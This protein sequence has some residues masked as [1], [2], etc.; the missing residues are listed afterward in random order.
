MNALPSSAGSITGTHGVCQGANAVAYSVGTIAN[1]TGYTWTLPSGATIAS[2]ANTNS[3][4][5]NFSMSAAS[6]NVTVLGTNSCGVGTVSPNYAV[7]VNAIPSKP[8]V[9][10]S[11]NTLTSSAS[12]GNQWYHNGTAVAGATA[13]VYTVPVANPGWYW[14]IVTLNG[15]SSDSSNHVY[16]A[17]VGVQENDNLSFNVYPVPNNG[18]FTAE[19]SSSYEENFRIQIYNTLGAM[20]YKTEEFRVS[21]THKEQID[22]HQLPAG[23]YSVVFMNDQR[24]VVRKVF[25]NK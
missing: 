12:S 19:V 13:Q 9:T 6:G 21:G 11:G 24:K 22:V 8:T 15:C 23:I 4:T 1:A 3:I 17:G 16:V 2:G 20:V 14:T 25:I 7:T 10:A 5:V 18:V